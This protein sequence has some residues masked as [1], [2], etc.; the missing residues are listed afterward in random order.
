MNKNPKD[1]Q[2]KMA[3]EAI[4]TAFKLVTCVGEYRREK[5]ILADDIAWIIQNEYSIGEADILDGLRLVDAICGGMRLK[6]AKGDTCA[7]RGNMRGIFCKNIFTKQSRLYAFY[8][9]ESG[10][11]PKFDDLPTLVDSIRT[12]TIDERCCAVDSEA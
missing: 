12:E 9:T 1:L 4:D 3:S 5:W 6:G 2:L 10:R 8:I 7:L 11:I